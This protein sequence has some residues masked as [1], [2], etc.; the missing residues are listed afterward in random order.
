MSQTLYDI[1]KF[2]NVSKVGSL[3]CKDENSTAMIINGDLVTMVTSDGNASLTFDK[4]ISSD[5]KDNSTARLEGFQ[6]Y[7]KA[8]YQLIV[9]KFK[10]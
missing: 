4:I 8:Y 6:N 2:D 3:F 10:K 7:I 5:L 9:A 1:A